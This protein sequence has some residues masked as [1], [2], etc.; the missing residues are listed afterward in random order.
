MG[1]RRS[2]KNS[3]DIVNRRFSRRRRRRRWIA[4]LSG[5]AVL[6]VAGMVILFMPR[7]DAGEKNDIRTIPQGLPE[8]EVANWQEKE[9]DKDQ[10]F[11]SL[12][13]ELTMYAGEKEANLSIMNPPY[14]AYD[15][16]IRIVLEDGKDTLLYESDLLVPGTY[17]QNVELLQEFQ[18]GS[19]DATVYYT[20]YGETTEV[21]LGEHMVPITIRVRG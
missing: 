11:I 2:K 21:V 17:C 6:A 18:K 5:A 7:S 4:G 3:L 16:D 1:K 8:A 14:S 15:F 19:Y 10:L 13:T 12:N 20:F 9:V